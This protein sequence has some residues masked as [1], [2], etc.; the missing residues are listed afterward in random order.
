M[1]PKR[2]RLRINGIKLQ[3]PIIENILNEVSKLL[4]SKVA[5]ITKNEPSDQ[6]RI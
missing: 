1:E 2:L 5:L 3:I 4:G 6:T